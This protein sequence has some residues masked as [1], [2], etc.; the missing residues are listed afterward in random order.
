MDEF[1]ASLSEIAGRARGQ[2]QRANG[3]FTNPGPEQTYRVISP[4]TLQETRE[5]LTAQPARPSYSV[6]SAQDGPGTEL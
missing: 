2:G 1:F 4:F 3:P 6:R 5:M